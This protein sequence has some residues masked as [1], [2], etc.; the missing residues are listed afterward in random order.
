MFT[1]L[2][3]GSDQQVPW[4][5]TQTDNVIDDYAIL[6]PYFTQLSQIDETSD[7]KDNKIFTSANKRLKIKFLQDWLEQA[8]DWLNKNLEE[9]LSY[10]PHHRKFQNYKGQVQ[11]TRQA[12]AP[13]RFPVHDESYNKC[14]SGVIYC[15]PQEGT[16]TGMYT[17]INGNSVQDGHTISIANRWGCA[18]W[19]P[20]RAFIFAGITSKTWHDYESVINAHRITVNLFI[21]KRK[22]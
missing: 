12:P 20:N 19:K 5:W 8:D 22:Q 11:I 6:L 7:L 13:Y 16:G 18:T 1:G 4:P 21:Q 17:N 14:W 10:W 9:L 2:S 3:K 15:A